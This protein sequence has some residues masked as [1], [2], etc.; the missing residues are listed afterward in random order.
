[1]SEIDNIVKKYGSLVTAISFRMIENRDL[2]EDAAQEAWIEI[3][4]SLPTFMGKSNIST[5]IYTIAARTILKHSK[6]ENKYSIRFISEFLNGEEIIYPGESSTLEEEEWT[7]QMCDKCITGSIHC[8]S[9]ED[10]LIY[11]LYNAAELNSKEISTIINIPD[12]TIRK[13]ISR[14]RNKLHSFLNNQCSLY[15]PEGN[16]KCRMSKNV[17]K[18]N[19]YKEFTKIK[20]DIHKIS[21]LSKC[22]DIL[23]SHNKFFDNLCHSYGF[24]RTN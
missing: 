5:W 24:P 3:I 16:C 15:N 12:D 9:N 22:D 4:K 13:R 6:K 1:M 17:I 18:N 8:L 21:F 11:L 14:S 2:A 7:K 19:I 20:S 23:S 10:R